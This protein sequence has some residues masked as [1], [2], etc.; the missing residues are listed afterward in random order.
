MTNEEGG[1]K[2]IRLLDVLLAHGN[3]KKR[4]SLL[5]RSMPVAETVAAVPHSSIH[6]E[7]PEFEEPEPEQIAGESAV[8]R[9][10]HSGRAPP[11][12]MLLDDGRGAFQGSYAGA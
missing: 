4:V 7:Q 1:E 6:H 12:L 3:G 11:M 10:D 2:R 9:P 8:S 5:D